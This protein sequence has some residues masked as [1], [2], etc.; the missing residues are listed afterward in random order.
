M[1][2]PDLAAILVLSDASFTEMHE[3]QRRTAV[4]RLWVT[5]LVLCP[6]I[7]G[8]PEAQAQATESAQTMDSPSDDDVQASRRRRRA[9][10]P[11]EVSTNRVLQVEFGYN[12]DF[13]SDTLDAAQAATLSLN[14]SATPDILIEFSHDNLAV[15]SPRGGSTT[16]G[17]GN[18][19]LGVQ[20]TVSNEDERRPSLG[21]SYQLTVPTGS[22][23]AGISTGGYWHR[24][25]LLLSKDVGEVTYDANASALLN[26]LGAGAAVLGGVQGVLSAS[27]VVRGRA[28][29]Q[30]EI[31][32][33]SR[34]ADEPRGVFVSSAL[35]YQ[36]SP[37]WQ[38]D[39]GFRMGLTSSAPR[40]GA[41]VGVTRAVNVGRRPR[42]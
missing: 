10:V 21:L 18:A 4:R 31:E 27:R 6:V 39:I 26:D 33:Q 7:A 35:T 22:R 8:G 25:T 11:A 38:W 34:D 37:T 23:S 28:G 36:A 13:W 5:A 24:A 12:G 42:P 41:F 15:Q 20:Y 1:I 2:L 29:V 30:L 14:Y 9:S 16:G 19:Y 40:A 3:R 32:G 17:V